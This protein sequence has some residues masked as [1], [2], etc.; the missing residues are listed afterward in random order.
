MNPE[1]SNISDVGD[2]YTFTLNNINVSLA[3]AI[4][5]TVLSDI[6]TLVFYTETYE[7][8]QCTILANTTRLHNEILKQRLSCIPI[9]ETDLNILPGT[10][11]LD[12][13]MQNNT[14]EKIIVT[15]EH[16]RIRNKTNG[17]YLSKDEQRR[18]FPANQKTQQY[19]DFARIRPRI[20]DTIPGEHI[21]LTAEFSVHTA[22]DNSMFNVVSKCSYGNTPDMKKVDEVWDEHEQKLRSEQLS[23]DEVEFEKKNFYLLDA[24]R[25]FVPDSFDFII[26]TIGVFDNKDIVRKACSIL[27]D[28]LINMIQL[29]DSDGVPINNSETTMDYCFDIILENEDYTIG[30]VLE[31]ILY[32]KYYVTEKIFTY[33]GFKKFHPH[34][35]DSTIRVAYSKNAD[36]RMVAQHLRFACMDAATIFKKVHDMFQK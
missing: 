4:R 24:Q 22:K 15:T 3:N 25:Y 29:I 30:K 28:K 23:A 35:L 16:F 21:K 34:N 2:V 14:D 27:H 18:I 11:I 9:H 7:D 32:E 6:P 10:Y 19:I 8:N 33:C 13:D 20:G 1:L 12:L 26:Q 5:R 17:N 31:Y 36:K